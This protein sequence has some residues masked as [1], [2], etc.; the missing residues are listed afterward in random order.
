MW[1]CVQSDRSNVEEREVELR[2][3]LEKYN[4]TDM[5][6]NLMDNMENDRLGV[7]SFLV[8]K[9]VDPVDAQ[10]MMMH[11]SS[12]YQL[13]KDVVQPL[14]TLETWMGQPPRWKRWVIFYFWGAYSQLKMEP[15]QSLRLFMD[16]VEVIVTTLGSH[17]WT[18]TREYI[19]LHSHDE[20]RR[21][22]SFL[23]DVM[24]KVSAHRNPLHCSATHPCK[25]SHQ[26]FRSSREEMLDALR[27]H[28]VG[29]MCSNP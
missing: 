1:A 17:E 10:K 20:H 29:V 18:R 6:H 24:T 4:A 12:L 16:I 13:H 25:N 19:V 7:S 15:N 27:D 2:R 5:L 23:M 22:I 28:V 26:Q 11:L 3:L 14:R 8:E 9:N 21:P